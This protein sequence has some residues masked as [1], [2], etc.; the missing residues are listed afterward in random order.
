M[1]PRIKMNLVASSNAGSRADEMAA[2]NRRE[3]NKQLSETEDNRPYTTIFG[4][5]VILGTSSITLE[6]CYNAN[7]KVFNL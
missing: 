2:H 5:K 3:F 4:R 7:L 6:D 1:R